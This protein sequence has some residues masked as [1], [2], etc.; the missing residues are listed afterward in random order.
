MNFKILIG[1]LILGGTL[2]PGTG[3][4]QDNPDDSTQTVTGC[5]RKG[6]GTDSKIYTLMDENGKLWDLRSTTVSFAPH[7]GHMVTVSGTIPQK[8]KK[9]GNADDTSPQN[10]LVVTKL[11]MVSETCQK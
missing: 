6:A 4:L 7:V 5:L 8:S 10:H 11:D 1:L 2:I 3:M 9:P